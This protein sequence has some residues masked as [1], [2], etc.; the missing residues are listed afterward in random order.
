MMSVLVVLRVR[1]IE[2]ATCSAG[3]CGTAHRKFEPAQFMRS[4][5]GAGTRGRTMKV[6]HCQ[7]GCAEIQAT[8]AAGQVFQSDR[9]ETQALRAGQIESKRNT[10]RLKSLS[11]V[12]EP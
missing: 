10:D 7:R 5:H 8:G 2:D 12:R 6:R 11:Y 4:T 1:V 9:I 3:C